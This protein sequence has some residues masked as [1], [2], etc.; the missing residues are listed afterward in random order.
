[1]TIA[2]R[3][4]NHLRSAMASGEAAD[5]LINRLEG[6]TAKIAGAGQAAL[7]NDTGGTPDGTLD[8]VGNTTTNQADVINKN[9]TELF[10]QLDAIRTALVQANIIKGG[11]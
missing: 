2:A 9:F 7:T 4:R 3:T 6:V 10:T 1:M 5:D 11:A 8:L